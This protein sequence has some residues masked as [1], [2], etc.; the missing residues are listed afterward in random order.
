MRMENIKKIIIAIDGHSSCGKST[1]AKDLAKKLAFSYID[2][3][4]MYRSVTYYALENGLITNGKIEAD[5]LKKAL[6]NIHITF[7]FDAKAKKNTTYLNGDN[8]EDQIR[9]LKVSNNVSAISALP[10][11]RK[12]LVD[13]QKAMG[14]EKGIVMDGRDIGT[15][16]FPN[17]E[18]KI[19]MTAS[20]STRAQ[21]RFDELTEKGE[22]VSFEDIL[23][24]IQQRDHLDQTREESPLIQAKDAITLDN[25]HLTK[26][27][28]LNWIVDK[29]TA[30]QL[31]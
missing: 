13:L 29:L 26:E 10:F 4:A 17:A 6:N 9:G 16:V 19:F 28:Q 27:Q 25:S 24:N 1:V 23:S 14:E 2:T 5:A 3:G 8:I 22:S 7:K 11:V 20:A 30:R 21:R 31:L 15:V 12:R 18:L